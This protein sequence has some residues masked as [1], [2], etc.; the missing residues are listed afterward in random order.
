MHL[1]QLPTINACL[2]FLSSLF[3]IAGWWFITTKR[4]KLHIISMLIAMVI[5][6]LFLLCYLIYHF[7]TQV[8]THFTAMGLIRSAYFILLIS[9]VL[10]AFSVLPLIVLTL[11]PAIQSRF[12]KHRHIAKWTLPIWLYVS[13]TGVLVY[14]MLYQWF[15]SVAPL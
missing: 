15:P 12:D 1:Q 10:L 9:H 6:I 5:S 8:V 11:I 2:N 14:M 7:N 4:K 3:I 13:I